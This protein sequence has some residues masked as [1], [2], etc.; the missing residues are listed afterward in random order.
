MRT[1]VSAAAHVLEALIMNTHCCHTFVQDGMDMNNPSYT[2]V[3]GACGYGEFA[4]SAWPYWRAVGLGFQNP[5]ST[6]PVPKNGCGTCLEITCSGYVSTAGHHAHSEMLAH[7]TVPAIT[8]DELIV[9]A[10]MSVL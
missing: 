4:R 5:L 2:L 3:N 1:H 7:V 9:A 10:L 8:G 6:Q